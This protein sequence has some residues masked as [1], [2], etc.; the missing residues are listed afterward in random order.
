MSR[1]REAIDDL[2]YRW[3]GV[4]IGGP[5]ATLRGQWA[6]VSLSLVLVFAC[7]FAIGRLR[8]GGG[9]ASPA[10]TPAALVS[11]A[12][13]SAI[14]T[15]LSGG[16][17]I[18]G[19]VPVA[20]AV[21]PRPRLVLAPASSPGLAAAT[22]SPSFT[23]ETARSESS[24]SE[25]QFSSAPASEPA[26]ATPSRSGGGSGSSRRS[27]AKGGVQSHVGRSFDSSE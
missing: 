3:L 10:A 8:A 26:P 4:H 7:F 16:S 17:P 20:I 18:A 23:G 5:D 9:G 12:G 19:A 22:P 27:S 25:S 6:A 24:A 11:P 1:A 2:R 21:R 14:P 13:Q 15:G